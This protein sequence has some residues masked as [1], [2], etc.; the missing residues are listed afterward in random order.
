MNKYI[1]LIIAILIILLAFYLTINRN[2]GLGIL[3]FI[4][5]IIPIFLFFRN[6][7]IFIAFWFLR[8]Q[9]IKTSKK[10]LNKIS[11]I[12]NQLH[13]TQYGYYNYLNGICESQNNPEKSSNYMKKA[14][15][16][17]LFFDHDKALA[18]LNLAATALRKGK[19]NESQE[20][21]IQVKKYDKSNMLIDQIKMIKNHSKKINIGKNMQNPDIR[22]KGRFFLK[23]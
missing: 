10:W 6:E 17:G 14:L 21:L 19:K 22:S 15:N 20:Y 4:I 3:L 8:K 13:Y 5:S 1:K 2:L 23:K 11:N 7:Y 16:L 18:Y 9:D 12:K